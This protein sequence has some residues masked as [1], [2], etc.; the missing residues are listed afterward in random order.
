M[1]ASANLRRRRIA[2]FLQIAEEEMR[3]AATL[4]NALPLQSAFFQQQSVEKLLRAV[5]E[6]AD[7]PAGPT[8]N[9]RTR[10]DLLPGEHELKAT[11]LAFEEMSSAA[12]RFRYPSGSGDAPQVSTVLVRAPRPS[13]DASGIG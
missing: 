10:A 1:T 3:A 7:I 12:T 5:L 6:A 13:G 2:A 9:L 8:H 4:L 11:F